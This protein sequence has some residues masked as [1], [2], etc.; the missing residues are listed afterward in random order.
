MLQGLGLGFRVVDLNI[1]PIIDCHWVGAVSK[2][3]AC[4][5][6]MRLSFG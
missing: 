2:S 4:L 3:L 5:L 6:D 1:N